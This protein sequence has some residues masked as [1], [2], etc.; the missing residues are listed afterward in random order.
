LVRM[1]LTAKVLIL[2]LVVTAG[3]AL[4]L[5]WEVL[6]Q[7]ERARPAVSTSAVAQKSDGDPVQSEESPV[8]E[9]FADREEAQGEFDSDPGAPDLAALDPDGNGEVCEEEF[10]DSPGGATTGGGQPGG[11]TTSAPS[12]RTTPT[13]PPTPAPR[14]T[15]PP[16]PSPTPPPNQDVGELMNAGGPEAGPVPKLPSGDCPKEFPQERDRACYS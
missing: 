10:G 8:C 11:S 9:D 6:A 4:R 1:R 5:G 14:P 15:P 3:L 7:G 16:Q 13:P 12:E 2:V